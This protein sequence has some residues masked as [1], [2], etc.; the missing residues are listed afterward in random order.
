MRMST[1]EKA[2][3]KKQEQEWQAERDLAAM[4]DV[5]QLKTDKERYKRALELR[6]RRLAELNAIK[7]T[8][9]E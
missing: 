9:D 3:M 1:A 7:V 4:I 2:R 6:D 5:E 8:Q